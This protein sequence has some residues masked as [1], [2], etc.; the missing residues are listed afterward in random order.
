MKRA[1]GSCATSH[2]IRPYSRRHQRGDWGNLD[3]FDRRQNDLAVQQGRRILSV[4]NAPLP[5]GSI[6]HIY[7][8]TE[9]D[10]SVTTALLP[11]EYLAIS[12]VILPLPA[13]R[14][15]GAHNPAARAWQLRA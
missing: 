15:V 12:H 5:V 4:Y 8:T 2:L 10:P 7:I 11:G 3:D 9:H 1:A 13:P 6:A 14:G